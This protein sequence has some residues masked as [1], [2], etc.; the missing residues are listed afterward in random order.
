MAGSRACSA[1]STI[2]EI[3]G[4]GAPLPGRSCQPIRIESGTAAP[5]FLRSGMDPRHSPL[6]AVAY[7]VEDDGLH[8]PLSLIFTPG[9]KL[10][11]SQEKCVVVSRQALERFRLCVKTE[12]L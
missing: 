7:E 9:S 5:A 4:T 1:T 12:T 3:D 2:G 11:L 8:L 6:P 10:E